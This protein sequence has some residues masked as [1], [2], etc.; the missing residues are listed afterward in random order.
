MG[1]LSV[2]DRVTVGTVAA[3][4]IVQ[5]L[6]QALKDASAVKAAF[7][8]LDLSG[9]WNY[10]PLSLLIVGLASW[11]WGRFVAP[12]QGAQKQSATTPPKA[13]TSSIERSLSDSRVYL[14]Q[15]LHPEAIRAVFKGITAHQAGKLV[16]PYIGKWMR[17]KGRF[18][19]L[20][21]AMS[22]SYWVD[23]VDESNPYSDTYH[24]IH[25]RFAVDP[26]LNQLELLTVGQE[27]GIAGQIGSISSGYISL[28]NCEL[29][30]IDQLSQAIPL[31]Y[32]VVP[33]EKK[34][35]RRPRSSTTRAAKPKAV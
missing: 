20:Q 18:A 29:L 17:V 16:A 22:G 30:S 12:A 7:P 8:I 35:P 31:G 24:G 25:F 23:L 28:N 34:K 10:V 26:W 13:G 15:S 32:K 6:Q 11:T 19:D 14:D 5:A 9:G 2:F 1:K 27:I 4:A 33:A 21:P 3:S